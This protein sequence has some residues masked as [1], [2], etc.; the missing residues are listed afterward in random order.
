VNAGDIPAPRFIV[1]TAAETRTAFVLSSIDGT[2]AIGNDG[3]GRANL[4]GVIELRREGQQ[5]PPLLT[6]NFALTTAGDRI[7]LDPDASATLEG[8]RLLVWP[9]KPLFP[10]AHAKG[11]SLYVPNVAGLFWSIPDGVEDADLFFAQVEGQSRKRDVAFLKNGDRI[12]GTLTT[13]GPK[14]GCVMTVAGKRV[15]T[16]WS[17]LAGVAWS[18][19]RS[20]RPRAKKLYARAV[21]TGGSRVSLQ[22]WHFDEKTRRF[23]GKTLLGVSLDWSEDHLLDLEVRQDRVTILSDLMPARYEHRPYLG[24]SWPLV[25]DAAVTGQP[26]RLRANTYEKGLGCHAACR[27]TYKLDGQY[28]RFDALVGLDELSAR[29]G[30]ARLA[31]ELDGKRVDF[32]EAKDLTAKD[33]PVLVRQDVDKVRELTLIVDNGA[34]GDVQ[35]HVN[36]V[37]ARLIRRE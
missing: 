3:G 25:K 16:P 34:F 18:T 11:L 35:A 5:L 6:A 15:E 7:A 4:A 19:E 23:S 9:A 13:L 29:R 33:A 1:E 31:L 8:N 36:W 14:A 12:E 28:T 30:R 37:N 17:K 20:V 2:T 32:N 24:A 22:D 26:L 27:I 10:A 21:L